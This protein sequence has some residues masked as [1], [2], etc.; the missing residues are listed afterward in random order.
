MP[1]QGFSRMLITRETDY[2]IRTVVYLARQEGRAANVT[3]VASAMGIPKAFLAKIVQRLVKR[4]I[5]ET[6]RGAK[7]GVR[8]LKEPEEIDLYTILEAI[9]GTAGINLCVSGRGTCGFKGTCAVHPVWVEMRKEVER[10][11]KTQTIKR[12]I[13]T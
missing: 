5:L 4:G 8:L 2:A 1:R 7:G 6:T 10:R 13:A 11:L 9:Q 3:R 12:L